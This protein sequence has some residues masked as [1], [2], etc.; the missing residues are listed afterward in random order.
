MNRPVERKVYAASLG[1]GVGTIISDFALWGIDQIWWPA[2]EEIVPLPVAGFVA[3]I[4]TV[5]LTFISGWWAKHD[6]G[7]TYE[8][9]GTV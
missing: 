4:V 6:P 1:A 9:S 8:E 5:G 7:A 3:L 2:E